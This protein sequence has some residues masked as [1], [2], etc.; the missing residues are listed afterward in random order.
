M[1]TRMLPTLYKRTS[2]GAVQEWTI[3]VRE[4]ADGTGTIIVIQGQK[5]GAKQRYEDHVAQGKNVGRK[6]ETTPL[7][8]AQAEAES[9]WNKKRDR[10]HYGL[11][12]E[13]SESK[14]AAA[15]MLAQP[16]EKHVAKIDWDLAFAQPKLDGHRCLAV[17]H[18]SGILLFS[19]EGKPIE[20]VPH[21]A[22]ELKGL[23]R[24][25]ETLDGELYLHGAPL[26]RISSLI[27]RAQEDSK[28]LQYRA[29][30]LVASAAF[31]ARFE[32]LARRDHLHKGESVHLVET[33]RVSNEQQLMQF[34]A[35]CIKDGYEGAM[36][37]WGQWDY[38]AGKR[39]QSLLKVKTFQDA[40]FKIVAVKEGRG[41]F[42]GMA[43]F[44]CHTSAGHPFDVT[45]PGKHEEKREAWKNRQKLI[46]KLVTIKYQCYTVTEEPVPFL[47][48]A[49]N[50]KENA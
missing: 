3:G 38:E 7:Q 24:A 50:L 1:S 12:V 30:D 9:E 26:A 45:A 29:Y 5:D 21:I 27:K 16:F 43:I 22:D 2:T 35:Q 46:G 48:V 13:E 32:E 25:D 41:T 39:S 20:T 36:L 40:E 28:K 8:Q 11:T 23:V 33:I 49:K 4:E 6:N 18:G 37:R 44:T 31:G 42:K 17:R 15:P 19:R 14:K 47:P 10:K 34:Q